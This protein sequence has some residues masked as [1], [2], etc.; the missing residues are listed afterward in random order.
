VDPASA[1][2]LEQPEPF[3]SILMH[4]QMVIERTIPEVSLH[5]KY[6][7]P[8]YYLDDKPFCYLNKS[9]DYV[10]V[11]FWMA[12]HITIHKEYMTTK[13]RKMM[14]SLRYFSLEN[15]DEGILV[16]VLRNAFD[17]KDRKFYK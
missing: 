16:D 6:K 13:G 15:I 9:N 2:I 3:R 12:A 14:K 5:Y 4:L 17:V 1:Y 11:G 7:I 8:F 10:D